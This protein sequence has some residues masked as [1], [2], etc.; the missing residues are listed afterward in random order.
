MAAN[1][2]VIECGTAFTLEELLAG[3]IGK[4]SSDKPTLRLH[5]SNSVSGSKYF[6][7]AVPVDKGTV[8]DALKSLFTLDGNG[9]IAIR[10]S[11]L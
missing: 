9:D 10:V 7:C 1:D 8:E 4:D 5:D 2:N 6:S 3:A 11:L